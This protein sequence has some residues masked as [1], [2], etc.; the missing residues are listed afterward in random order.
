MRGAG[1]RGRPGH[2]AGH[3]PGSVRF[4][5]DAAAVTVRLAVLL[6]GD[7]DVAEAVARDSLAALYRLRKRPQK[8]DVAVPY[9]RRLPTARSRLAVTV[10]LRRLPAGQREMIVL[11]LCPGPQPRAGRRGMRVSL[12]TLGR[13]LAEARSALRAVLPSSR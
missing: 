5:R 9:M 11:T 4:V 13:R 3:P 10:A 12:A 1:G 8:E 6:T 7:A 2:A